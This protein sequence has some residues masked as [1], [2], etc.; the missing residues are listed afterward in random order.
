MNA[1]CH[2]ESVFATNAMSALADSSKCIDSDHWLTPSTHIDKSSPAG[3]QFRYFLQTCCA[4]HC[5]LPS[6]SLD[7]CPVPDELFHNNILDPQDARLTQ[8]LRRKDLNYWLR[9]LLHDKSPGD[10]ELTY[11]MR[12]EVPAKIADA[13]YQVLNQVMQNRKMP[14]SWDG[15]PTTLIP[16]MLARKNVKINTSDLPHE[17]GCQNSDECLGQTTLKA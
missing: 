6:R 12:Q 7:G 17:H 4:I 8:H 16:K 3:R 14:T 15:A 2:E 11:K 1:M 10:D 5:T 13:L 9:Q